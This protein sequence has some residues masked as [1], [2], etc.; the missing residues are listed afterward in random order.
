MQAWWCAALGF[1]SSLGAWLRDRLKD[2]GQ[3]WRVAIV[4]ILAVTLFSCG[5]RPSLVDAIKTAPAGPLVGA[6]SEVAPPAVIQRLARDLD[7]YQ[8]QVTIISPRADDVLQTDRV[9]VNLA[10]TGLPIFRDETLGLGPHLRLWLDDQPYGDIY[11]LSQPIVLENLTAG[12]HTLRAIALRPWQE[13]FKN[14]G[15]YAQSSF[16]LFARSSHNQH[17]ADQPLLTYNEP[18]GT[19]AAGQPVL[20]DFYLTNA[21]LHAIARQDDSDEIKDWRIRA[22]VNGETFPIA[23]WQAAYLQ[24][25]KPGKNWVKLELVDEAGKPLNPIFNETV[26]ALT[27]DRQ[28]VDEPVNLSLIHI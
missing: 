12:T 2:Q 22:T 24:G 1:G 18:S 3:R 20:L 23:N 9:D 25:F 11:D 13:S 21:P 5:D 14:E 15:A 8:P 6:I 19:Y 28:P 4:L 10:V 27:I 26:V 16:H 7:R 17:D